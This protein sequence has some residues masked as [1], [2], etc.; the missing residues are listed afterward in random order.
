VGIVKAITVSF[1]KASAN[2]VFSCTEHGVSTYSTGGLG[3]GKGSFKVQLSQL[4]S[5]LSADVTVKHGCWLVPPRPAVVLTGQPDGPFAL[6]WST[7]IW[8]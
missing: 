1:S 6:L 4:V 2:M 8:F 3:T 7:S 5:P